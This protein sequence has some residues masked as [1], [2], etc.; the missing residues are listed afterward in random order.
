MFLRF[1]LYDR[2][3]SVWLKSFSAVSNGNFG[4]DASLGARQSDTNGSLGRRQ[5]LWNDFFSV[6]SRA[7][8][9]RIPGMNQ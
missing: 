4:A 9:H 5:F 3:Q 2:V 1:A 7:I 8:L 6:C